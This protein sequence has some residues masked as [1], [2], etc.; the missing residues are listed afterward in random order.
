MQKINNFLDQVL[1]RDILSDI[2]IHVPIPLTNPES[3]YVNNWRGTTKI[4]AAS[5]LAA[6]YGVIQNNQSKVCNGHGLCNKEYHPRF[7][8][9]PLFLK[10]ANL[11]IDVLCERLI[12]FGYNTLALNFFSDANLETISSYGLKSLLMLE[13]SY[14]SLPA[15]DYVY[16]PSPYMDDCSKTQLERAVSEAFKIIKYLHKHSTLIFQPHQTE[17]V[18]W[19]N[20][21]L[22]ELPDKTILAF[23]THERNGHLHPFWDILHSSIDVSSTSIMPILNAGCLGIGEGLWPLMLADHIEDVLLKCNSHSFSG[24]L[25]LAA[26]MPAYEAWGSLNLWIAARSQWVNPICSCQDIAKDWFK[27]YRPD[28]DLQLCLEPIKLLTDLT[29]KVVNWLEDE[30]TPTT[31]CW[32][33]KLE[34]AFSYLKLISGYA[35]ENYTA[36]NSAYPSL[37]DYFR[38]CYVDLRSL[39]FHL[40]LKHQIPISQ[41]IDSEDVKGGFWTELRGAPG[42]A[43]RSG[44]HVILRTEPKPTHPAMQAIFDLEKG[45]GH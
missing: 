9:R 2:N 13:G 10:N 35:W 23:P 39:L 20:K 29:H 32:R 45:K 14:K 21:L 24:F 28:I 33:S 5:F 42:Q 41:M 1:G 6:A 40:I 16:Y 19:W 44:G 11:P 34:F 26:N 22:D 17:S 43:V 36:C 31:E 3:F 15:V 8:I 12:E 27:L 4:S 18:H 30:S 7:P 37:E 25:S 38:Y